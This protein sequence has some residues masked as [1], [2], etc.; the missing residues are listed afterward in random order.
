MILRPLD[1]EAVAVRGPEML[2]LPVSQVVHIIRWIYED[3]YRSSIFFGSNGRRHLLQNP[4]TNPLNLFFR[5][6]PNPSLVVVFYVIMNNMIIW[7]TIIALH[8]VTELNFYID[9]FF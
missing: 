2:L 5:T 4:E 7:L 9:N 6:F 1:A 8:S 3:E